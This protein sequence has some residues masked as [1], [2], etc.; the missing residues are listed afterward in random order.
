[1]ATEEV[2]LQTATKGAEE[3]QAKLNAVVAEKEKA[4]ERANSAD[5]ALGVERS[6]KDQLVAQ[7]KTKDK[8][9]EELQSQL[10][11]MESEKK[12]AEEVAVRAQIDNFRLGYDDAVLQAKKLGFDYTKL[13]LNPDIDTTLAAEAGAEAEGTDETRGSES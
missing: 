5:Q 2:K 12:E 9:I 1:M 7:L 13:L 8:A 10:Q 3:M 6:L 11:A 4:V